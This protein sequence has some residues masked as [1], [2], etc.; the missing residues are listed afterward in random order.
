[1]AHPASAVPTTSV[2]PA[3]WRAIASTF[4]LRRCRSAGRRGPQ[5]ISEALQLIEV[6]IRNH[7]PVHRR[8]SP[9]QHVVALPD[10]L[11]DIGIGRSGS[12]PNINVDQMLPALVDQNRH[13]TT[14]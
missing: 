3:A 7:P 12:W 14:V 1:M 4:P 10:A 11:P 8:T 6:Q 9:V 5:Q 13:G 2:T